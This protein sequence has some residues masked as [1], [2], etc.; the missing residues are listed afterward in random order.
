M[1]PISTRYEPSHDVAGSSR[2]SLDS[3]D[4]SNR[5]AQ[6]TGATLLTGRPEHGSASMMMYIG[7]PYL[8]ARIRKFVGGQRWKTSA[9]GECDTL[10]ENRYQA[11]SISD[12]LTDRD[13]D[14]LSKC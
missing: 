10:R 2:S 7:E 11:D 9:I 8:K 4:T 13:L 5:Q 14:V 1:S 12:E 3:Y 6:D